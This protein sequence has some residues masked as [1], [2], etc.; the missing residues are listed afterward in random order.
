M[1]EHKRV[2]LETD[3]SIYQSGDQIQLYAHVLDDAYDPINQSGFEVNITR[4][5]EADAPPQR[6]TLRPDL[7]TPGLYE[8]YFSPQRP[9]RYRLEANASDLEISSTTEFQVADINPEMAN[10]D[11]QRERLQ[12]MADLSGGKYLT[13]RQ[14][15]E[16][17]T[18][19]NRDPHTTTVRTDRSLWDNGW[20]IILLVAL[21]GFEWIVR[22]KYDLS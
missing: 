2:R 4:Q 12:K 3:Q 11:M 18:L 9:G 7:S 6:V 15:H 8:G 5:D 16:L 21:M 17:P 14:L 10:A 22:R 19:V 1:G 20:I 13:A